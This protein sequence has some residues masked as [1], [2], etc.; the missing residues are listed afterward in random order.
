MF[1]KVLL[2]EKKFQTRAECILVHKSKLKELTT[3]LLCLCWMSWFWKK[4]ED[5]MKMWLK[6]KCYSST[7]SAQCAGGDPERFR[8]LAWG[9]GLKALHVCV[10]SKHNKHYGT[11]PF[12]WKYHA[13][14]WRIHPQRET[15][16]AAFPEWPL[17]VELQ[18]SNLF[19]HIILIESCWIIY[20]VSCINAS[21]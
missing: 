1:W 5:K 19:N 7:G 20:H 9:G 12:N 14:T 6:A 2:L 21:Y 4:Q 16:T 17:G 13:V 11:M 3:W 10:W 8:I 15:V 18:M